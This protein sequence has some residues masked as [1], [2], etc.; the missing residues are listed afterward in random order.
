LLLWLAGIVVVG[1]TVLIL[2]RIDRES[3]YFASPPPPDLPRIEA[4]EGAQ[5]LF[6]PLDDSVVSAGYLNEKYLADQGYPHYAINLWAPGT[7]EVLSVGDGVVLGTELCDNSVGNIAVIRY[8]DVY[9]PETGETASLIARYYHMTGTLVAEGD[10]VTAG[11]QI[12]TID[13]SHQWYN[14]VHIE[15][16]FDVEHPFHTPQVAEASSELLQRYPADGSSI[17]DP[18]AVLSLGEA[19]RASSHKNAE[20]CTDTDVPRFIGISH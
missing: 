4:P 5:L 16:D 13:G 11:R 8:D 10:A 14:H 3:T 20:W 2:L 1:V 15:L 7:R 12:G 9:I 19:Q 18:F 17:A 6:F